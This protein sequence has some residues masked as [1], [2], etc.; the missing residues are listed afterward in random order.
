[1]ALLKQFKTPFGI[2]RILRNQDGTLEYYQNGCFHSQATAK[3]VSIC[4]Y[5]HIIYQIILQKKGRKVLSIGCG[6]GTLPTMLSR[7]G[8]DVTVVDINPAAFTIARDYFSMPDTVKCVEHDGIAFIRMAKQTYDAVVIDVFDNANKVPRA[9]TTKGFLAAANKKLKR[10]G[11]LIMNV[12]TKDDAD[13]SAYRVAKNMHA[14]GMKVSIYDWPTEHDRNTIVVG[15]SLAAVTI[16]SG[17]EPSFVKDD[18]KGLVRVK[19]PIHARDR[20]RPSTAL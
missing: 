4:A 9:F 13:K 19:P 14:A 8:C 6:G 2:I 10:G 3:G 12:M 17:N 11:V 16:P 7:K 1:M 20:R 5:V 15:G 18:F